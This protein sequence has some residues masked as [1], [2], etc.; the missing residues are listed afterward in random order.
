MMHTDVSLDGLSGLVTTAQAA[1]VFGVGQNAIQ[2]RIWRYRIPCYRIGGCL[3]VRLTDIRATYQR[4][5][6]GALSQGD[7]DQRPN[8]PATA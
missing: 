2:Q 4:N 7:A 8:A 5:V 6:H 3:L 1:R